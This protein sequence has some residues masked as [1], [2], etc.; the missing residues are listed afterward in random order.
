[1][2][3]TYVIHPGG[4]VRCAPLRNKR[5]R[6]NGICEFCGRGTAGTMIYHLRTGR[7]RC[8]GCCSV[9]D[10]WRLRDED[11]P[12]LHPLPP[13]QVYPRGPRPRSPGDDP[14]AGRGGRHE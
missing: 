4:W 2:S 14:G 3:R 12:R 13:E 5:F 9:G 8:L 11:D 1:V 6:G 7:C 10:L